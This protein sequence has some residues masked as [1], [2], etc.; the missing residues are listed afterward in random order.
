MNDF[1]KELEY[2]EKQIK[3]T[4]FAINNAHKKPN[5]SEIEI[6]NL[7]EKMTIFINIKRLI[8]ERIKEVEYKL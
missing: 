5:V 4:E 8:V 3:K 7:N 1:K 2:I 6:T